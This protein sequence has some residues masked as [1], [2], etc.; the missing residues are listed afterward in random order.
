MRKKK[1]FLPLFYCGIFLFTTL[2]PVFAVSADRKSQTIDIIIE[3][4]GVKAQMAALPLFFQN[5]NLL[6]TTGAE[7]E[8]SKALDAIFE[9]GFAPETI[10]AEIKQTLLKQYNEKYAAEVLKFYDSELGAKIAQCEIDSSSP[11]FMTGTMEDFDI[12]NYDQRRRQV[13]N[14]LF[15]DMKT[16]AFESRLLALAVEFMF[17]SI[18]AILPKESR[19]S[20]ADVIEMSKKLGKMTGSKSFGDDQAEN[21][22]NVFYFTYENITTDE[23][24]QYDKFIKSKPGQWLNQCT[25]NGLLSGM[26]KCT[27]QIILDLTAYTDSHPQ[28]I[29]NNDTDDELENEIDTGEGSIEDMGDI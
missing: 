5:S 8:R 18:N 20:D 24:E 22:V 7:S 29:L 10:V 25:Q 23:L 15:T 3:K 19:T 13:V 14:R 21:L 2:C 16:M 12:E 9:T 4:S 11:D 27:D 1:A 26:K 6:K 28:E 17:R